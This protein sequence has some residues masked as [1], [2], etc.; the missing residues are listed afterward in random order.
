[1]SPNGILK[2]R[3]HP[4][5]CGRG[6]TQNQAETA[7][8]LPFGASEKQSLGRGEDGGAGRKAHAVSEVG[9]SLPTT[10]GYRRPL[11][12]GIFA[13]EQPPAAPPCSPFTPEAQIQA[14]AGLGALP[15]PGSCPLQSIACS[16][17][18]RRAPPRISAR[19][20]EGNHT[21]PTLISNVETLAVLKKSSILILILFIIIKNS[22]AA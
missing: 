17:S 3:H 20:R 14:G 15:A 13:H 21:D 5:M 19:T 11:G 22:Q 8:A 10:T 7:G 9:A 1:M 12:G 18:A 2:R 16:G 6:E 4:A